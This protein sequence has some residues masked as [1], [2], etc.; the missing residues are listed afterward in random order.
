L[1]SC[2]STPIFGFNKE[3]PGTFAIY[4]KEPRKPTLHD[5]ELID[6]IIELTA[7]AIASREEDFEKIIGL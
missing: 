2:W 3:L 7:I 1:R 4:Y 5:L 6:E